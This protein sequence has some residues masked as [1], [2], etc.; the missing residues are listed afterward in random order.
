MKETI[1]RKGEHLEVA[2]VLET[3]K[4]RLIEKRFNLDTYDR[5]EG[6]IESRRNR[7]DKIILGAYRKVAIVVDKTENGRIDI[8]FEWGGMTTAASISFMEVFLVSAAVLRGFGAE[9]I[10]AAVLFGLIG[11]SINGVFFHALRIRFDRMLIK[12]I[13]DLEREAR[14]KDD[15]E[16][17]KMEAPSLLE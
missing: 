10:L 4:E 17:E 15:D 1:R 14:R 5:K 11:S 12:D 16:S 9:G 13:G 6:R 3:I 8:E 7:L 2:V